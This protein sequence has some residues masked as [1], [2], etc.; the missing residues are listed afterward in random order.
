MSENLYTIPQE[1]KV[2]RVHSYRRRNQKIRTFPVPEQ[3][4][5][6]VTYQVHGEGR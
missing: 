5:T 6:N 2:E 3:E 4:L 1:K